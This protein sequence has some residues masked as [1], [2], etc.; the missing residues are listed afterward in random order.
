MGNEHDERLQRYFDG[1]LAPEERARFEAE[2][3]ADD[4]ERL[5]A[6]GEMRALVAGALEG[7]ADG[8]DLW[9]AIEGQ[10]MASSLP[11]GGTSTKRAS[12]ARR[13]RD[14]G[15][16]R[17]LFGTGTGLLLAAAATLVLFLYP[18]HPNHPTNGCDIESLE[19]SGAVATVIQVADEPHPGD[20]DTTIIWTQEDK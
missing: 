5:A 2:L 15:R 20:G 11:P 10:V 16:G 14:R 13:L 19:V 18:R 6:L 8:V 17:R 1:E 3:T 12:A 9:S 4:R 7:A